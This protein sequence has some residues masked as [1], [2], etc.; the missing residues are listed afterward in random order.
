MNFGALAHLARA[1][2]WQRRGDQFESGMLH[3]FYCNNGQVAQL[4]RAPHSHCG[5]REFE[6]L[7]AHQKFV[8]R[9][10]ILKKI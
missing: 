6:S 1:L 8:T 4:A 3:H 2:R 5:G 10:F 9:N 7:S